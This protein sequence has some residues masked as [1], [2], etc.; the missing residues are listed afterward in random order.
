MKEEKQEKRKLNIEKRTQSEK[1]TR[2]KKFKV[3]NQKQI[4][5]YNQSFELIKAQREK[6][7]DKLKKVKEKEF[8]NKGF[9]SFKT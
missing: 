4:N 5:K 2:N 8:F 7:I 1:N 6:K 9:I 3:F